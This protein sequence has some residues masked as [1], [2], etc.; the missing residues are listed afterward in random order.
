M[1]QVERKPKTTVKERR[2][3]EYFISTSAAI[4]LYGGNLGKPISARGLQ[5][6]LFQARV[7]K[8]MIVLDLLCFF[9]NVKM[10]YHL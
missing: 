4:T 7:E 5:E 9:L 10:N 2:V 8:D 1:T 3:Q 6:N